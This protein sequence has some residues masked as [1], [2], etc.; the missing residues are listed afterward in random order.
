MSEAYMNLI[1]RTFMVLN[2]TIYDNEIHNNNEQDKNF[3]DNEIHI[4]D[5]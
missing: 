4:N 3:N 5:K 2:N 1:Q